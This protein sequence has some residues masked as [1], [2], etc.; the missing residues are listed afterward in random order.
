M[1][2]PGGVV[3]KS[4]PANAGDAG[5]ISGSGRSPEGGNGNPPQYSCLEHSMDKGAWHVTVHG[6]TKELDTAELLNT[7]MCII[8]CV[9]VYIIPSIFIPTFLEYKQT[10]S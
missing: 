7:H 10:A 2:F 4:L 8:I 5:L 6:V 3:V 1:G 9:Y